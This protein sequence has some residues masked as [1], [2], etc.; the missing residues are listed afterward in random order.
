MAPSGRT[1]SLRGF[2]PGGGQD[3]ARQCQVDRA[4]RLTHGDVERAVDHRF[5]RLAAAQLVVPLDVFAQHAA[6]VERL[7]AP[8][9]GSVTRSNATGLGERRAAGGEQHR[10]VVARG[11]DDAVHRVRRADGDVHHDRGGLAGDAVVAVRHGHGDVLVRHRHE[12]RD[13]GV[14][15]MGQRLHDRGKIRP[16]IGEHIVDAALA[17][18]RDIGLGRHAVVGPA[19]GHDRF[20][21]VG[22]G[23]CNVTA[24]RGSVN[25]SAGGEPRSF[26]LAGTLS[27]R[28]RS[29]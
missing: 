3:F 14:L 12:A 18:A 8:M 1:V 10:N 28:C 20:H 13:L 24:R 23:R 2:T 15:G 29:A 7:L 26:A 5:H 16:G 4:A 19:V 22:I 21:S 6:L 9:N 11:I 25:S 27:D 17:E